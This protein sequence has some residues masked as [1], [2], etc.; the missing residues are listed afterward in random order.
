MQKKIQYA[1]IPFF[2]I[3]KRSIQISVIITLFGIICLSL[4]NGFIYYQNKQLA[5]VDNADTIIVLGAHIEGN[6]L[7]PSLMLQYR[8]DKVIEY[9]LENPDVLIVTTGGQTPGYSQSEAQVM[10]QYLMRFGIPQSQILLEDQS[11]RTAHQFINAIR[12]MEAAHKNPGEVII[13]TNDFHLPRS[14]MLAKRSGLNTISGFA[15]K[16]PNDIGSKITAHIREPLA[17]LNSWLFD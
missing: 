14:M 1:L 10:Q 3:L 17:Y 16:T 5:P 13:I 6:P 2:K 12:V 9:W 4:G 8:L 15:G 11:T 7:R